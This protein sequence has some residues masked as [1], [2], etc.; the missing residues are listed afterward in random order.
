MIK[1]LKGPSSKRKGHVD[2]DK[3]AVL[4]AWHR[5]NCRTREAL[6]R[7]FLSEV[8]EGYEVY[9]NDYLHKSIS[10]AFIETIHLIDLVLLVWFLPSTRGFIYTL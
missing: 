9:L 5:V 10:H 8:I 6:R 1:A 7:S 2:A 4:N 3:I